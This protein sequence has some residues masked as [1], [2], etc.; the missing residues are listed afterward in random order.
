MEIFSKFPANSNKIKKHPIKK[1]T[2]GFILMLFLKWLCTFENMNV[3]ITKTLAQS[4]PSKFVAQGAFIL[5]L[6]LELNISDL[7]H[8]IE[9]TDFLL[10]GRSCWS[11]SLDY[12][13]AGSQISTA[14]KKIVFSLAPG[15]KQVF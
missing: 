15:L 14:L 11:D 1:F 12:F 7:I 13:K 8:V 5:N 6:L 4:S 3:R 2:N 10:V 9:S